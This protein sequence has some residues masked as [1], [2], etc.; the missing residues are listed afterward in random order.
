MAVELALLSFVSIVL[1][2][3]FIPVKRV[4][5]SVPS[6]AILLWLI[7]CNLVH[8]INALI[9]AGNVNVHVPVWC[10]IGKS[11]VGFQNTTHSYW[12]LSDKTR[13]GRQRR[14]A[15]SIFMHF[16]PPRVDIL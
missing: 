2:G 3:V 9:W 5:T 11:S 4:R 12:P 15:W 7:G 6:L 16:T 14:V 10:D 8:G 1:L 13:V